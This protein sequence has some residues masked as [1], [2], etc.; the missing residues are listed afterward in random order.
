MLGIN[1]RNLLSFYAPLQIVGGYLSSRDRG[2]R[3]IQ[4]LAKY[5]DARSF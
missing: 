3:Q 5:V 2:E 4:Y 1:Q